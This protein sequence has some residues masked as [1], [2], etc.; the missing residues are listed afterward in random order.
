MTLISYIRAGLLSSA[1]LVTTAIAT[2]SL[3]SSY[4][5]VNKISPR[6][7]EVSPRQIAS[8]V[9]ILRNAQTGT[10][11][12]VARSFDPFED[13]HDL[14][15][16]AQLRSV[17]H[18]VSLEGH[19]LRGGAIL[20]LAFYYNSGSSDPYDYRGYGDA[21]FL[22]G[23][24][25][26]VTL[27]DN[28]VLECSQDLH[29]VVYYHDDYYASSFHFN[30][31]RPTR[32]Y[33]GFNGFG[34]SGFGRSGF[35]GFNSFGSSR[36]LGQSFLGRQ[37]FG[38]SF[39]R[40]VGNRANSFD[41]DN[42][43]NRDRD[44]NRRLD[45]NVT[46]RTNAGDQDRVGDNRERFRDARRRL[47]DRDGREDTRN[48]TDNRERFREA[49]RRL[50]ES[51]DRTTPP[52]GRGFARRFTGRN[53]TPAVTTTNTAT[54]SPVTSAAISPPQAAPRV[55]T[56]RAA[57][58][59]ATTNRATSP[60][61][62]TQNQF[63]PRQTTVKQSAA[64]RSSPK[65]SSP[66]KS[67]S[68]TSS[69]SS[70]NSSSSRHSSRNSS[71]NRNRSQNRSRSSNSR[72]SSGLRGARLMAL[73]PMASFFGRSPRQISIQCAREEVLSFHIPQDR[74]EA[75]RYDGLTVIVLDR[76]GY[77]LPV[78]IPPNYIDGFR[79]AAAYHNTPQRPQV[80]APFVHQQPHQPP[81]QQ[82]PLRQ[83]APCP[84][85]TI[86]QSDGSCL[87]PGYPRP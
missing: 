85:G 53:Q 2:P 55:S 28:R 25:A 30:L 44:R 20:D 17:S 32:F 24:Y 68:R 16:N 4:Q 40:G 86:L 79:Q 38:T 57:T 26:A 66:R 84:A 5:S 9:E 12:I 46:P 15:G 19:Q 72:K 76:T 74:L 47:R 60:R 82:A 77:E 48:N 80:V 87:T 21:V 51:D 73:G 62:A 56:R 34:R 3:A 1:L 22:S 64:R 6:L 10:T 14:A 50:R 13:H 70:K 83:T 27:R 58:P 11:Q 18:D 23:N 81:Q 54:P 67:S 37:G 8:D 75:A 45:D 63:V 43:R 78:F 29:D 7:T 39:G 41:A 69:E 61:P 31:F 65:Q 71:S 35:G 52:R 49:R 36:V 59:R 42:R 33:S